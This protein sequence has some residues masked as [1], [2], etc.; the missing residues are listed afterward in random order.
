MTGPPGEINREADGGRTL[1]FRRRFPHPVED[2]WSAVTESERLARWFGSYEGVGSPGGTVTLTMTAE[3][4][5]GGEP[6]PVHILECEPPRRLVV[7]LPE[8]AARTWRIALTLSE[9]GGTTMLLF[10]QTVPADMD[11]TDVGPGWHWYL[12]RLDASLAGSPM[13][14]WND[15]HPALKSAYR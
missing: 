8:S 1:V 7:D 5:A 6:S 9:E 2:V 11:V 13:P 12:D 4:D 10:E 3:E 15:Y 14:D